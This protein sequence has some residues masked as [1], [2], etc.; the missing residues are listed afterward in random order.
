MKRTIY[1]ILVFMLLLSLVLPTFSGCARENDEELSEIAS[2]LLAESAIVNEIC[3]GAGLSHVK[4]ATEGYLTPGYAEATAEARTRFGVDT[5][6]EIQEKMYAVYSTATCD[7]INSVIFQPVLGDGTVASY[8][9]YFDAENGEGKTCLMVKKDYDVFVFG[10]AT[11][12]NVRVVKH[13]RSRAE[14]KV[15]ITVTD[16]EESRTVKDITFPLRYEDG[17]R[18]DTVTYAS[19]K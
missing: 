1:K 11:Y 17:W 14:I 5:V 3:F 15:D 13:T 2:R 4:D 8:R 10:V 19:I 12:D 6:A 7:Y 16:G 9:R 18:L